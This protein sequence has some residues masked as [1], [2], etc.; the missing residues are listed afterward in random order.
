MVRGRERSG[1]ISIEMLA[2]DMENETVQ[3]TEKMV[4]IIGRQAI[5]FQSHSGARSFEKMPVDVLLDPPPFFRAWP[6]PVFP[7]RAPRPP[8]D[9]PT[10]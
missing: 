7:N 4:D 6:A 9:W 8:I 3:V 1:G 10:N 5:D 2:I